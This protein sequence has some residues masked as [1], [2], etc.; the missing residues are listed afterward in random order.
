MAL[1]QKLSEKVKA[2][3]PTNEAPKITIE[4]LLSTSVKR[5]INFFNMIVEDHY[6]NIILM[7]VVNR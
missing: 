4:L 1:F 3:A 7:A 2:N 5:A 6:F